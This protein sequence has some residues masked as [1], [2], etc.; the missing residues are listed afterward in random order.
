MVQ[1]QYNSV[2]YIELGAISLKKLPTLSLSYPDQLA[3]SRLIQFLTF[4]LGLI[5]GWLNRT[6]TMPLYPLWQ[7]KCNGVLYYLIRKRKLTR[8]NALLQYPALLIRNVFI[9]GLFQK[10]TCKFGSTLLD[11][12]N[13]D[14]ESQVFWGKWTGAHFW[15]TITTYCLLLFD[16]LFVDPIID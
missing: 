11:C 4:M 6:D 16:L 15:N 12:N 2:C 1:V 7:A 13:T 10:L 3:N 9:T 14:I 8:R 5:S